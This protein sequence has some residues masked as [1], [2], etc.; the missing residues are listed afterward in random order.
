VQFSLIYVD[1]DHFS[2]EIFQNKLKEISKSRDQVQRKRQELQQLETAGGP[3]EKKKAIETEIKS[4]SES[5]AASE[6]RFIEMHA[7][8]ERFRAALKERG[9]GAQ[10]FFDH[11]NALFASFKPFPLHCFNTQTAVS[12]SFS[13]FPPQI[14]FRFITCT[15][16]DTSSASSS[17]I[18]QLPVVIESTDLSVTAFNDPV[19]LLTHSKVISIVCRFSFW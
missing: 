9:S 11:T 5:L 16:E 15:H 6:K 3:A 19:A 10:P 17:K 12:P 2:D 1:R 13:V 4:G 14:S 18:P 8:R 7:Q